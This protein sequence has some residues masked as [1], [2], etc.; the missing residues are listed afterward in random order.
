MPRDELSRWEAQ[1]RR[2]AKADG[3]ALFRAHMQF[4]ALPDAPE[5]LL[6][7][8]I[9]FVRA[10]CAY[11]NID[12]CPI[13]QF[14]SLQTYKPTADANSNYAFTFHVSDRIYSRLVSPIQGKLI[15]LA[16]LFNHPWY[17]FKMSGYDG[18]RFSRLD[19]CALT[20]NEQAMLEKEIE[21]DIRFDYSENEVEFWIEEDL[22]E[23]V[24]EVCVCEA[25]MPFAS[26]E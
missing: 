22:H 26:A 2:D 5:K 17:E 19:Q 6:E 4:V 21:N 20:I 13:D 11:L 23:G 9:P 25:D 16:D 10:S 7:G 12:A 24:L 3:M 15:D 8:T 14:L 18:F 1:F